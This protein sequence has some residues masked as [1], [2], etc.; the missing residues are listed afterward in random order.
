MTSFNLQQ[1]D[2]AFAV[3]WKCWQANNNPILGK[4]MPTCHSESASN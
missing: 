4:S 2:F 3:I 1:P